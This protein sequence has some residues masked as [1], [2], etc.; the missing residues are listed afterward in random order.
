MAGPAAGRRGW[1]R[2]VREIGIGVDRSE[3]RTLYTIR[4]AV[5]SHSDRGARLPEK[6]T[7]GASPAAVAAPTPFTRRNPS[8]DPNG[9]SE[10]RLATILFARAGPTRGSRSSSAI[11]ATSRSRGVA[12]VGGA[13]ARPRPR[14]GAKSVAGG[15]LPMSIRGA[16]GGNPI[17]ERGA[18]SGSCRPAERRR[19]VDVQGAGT[20]ATPPTTFGTLSH[21]FGATNRTLLLFLDFALRLA[22]LALSTAVACLASACCS[23]AEGVSAGPARSTLTPAERS[24]IA[25]RK[26]SAFC[27]DGVGMGAR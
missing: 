26:P 22:E 1:H 25:A 18:G 9:P 3:I 14:S 10:S 12:A 21:P 5:A 4:P 16:G 23:A 7:R 15:G 20:E 6:V 2:R 11:V 8:I 19:P 17:G 27:S 24:A 13:L